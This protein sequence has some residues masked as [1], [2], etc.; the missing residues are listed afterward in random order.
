M[1]VVPRGAGKSRV[2]PRPSIDPRN[3]AVKQFAEGHARIGHFIDPEKATSVEAFS[4][5]DDRRRSRN[6]CERALVTNDD[7]T[8]VIAHAML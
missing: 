1:I 3:I 4:S 6:S 7:F 2:F 8:S 5:V